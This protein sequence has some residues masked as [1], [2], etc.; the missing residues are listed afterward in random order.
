M[1]SLIASSWLG[2]F[3]RLTIKT[4]SQNVGELEL[5]ELQK[6]IL[7][8]AENKPS[9]LWLGLNIYLLPRRWRDNVTQGS[10]SEI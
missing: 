9:Q 10:E 5:L 4:L 1:G 8:P 3:N 2:R 7:K 6:T